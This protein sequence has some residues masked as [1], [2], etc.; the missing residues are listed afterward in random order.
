MDL[1]AVHRHIASLRHI[2]KLQM[3]EKGFSFDGKY[4]LYVDESV[5]VYVL[6]TAPITQSEKKMRE[7]EVV[8]RVYNQEVTT[9]EPV[10]FGTIVELDLCYMVLR[11][12]EGEDAADLLPA[13]TSDQQYQIGVEAGRQLLL[14]HQLDAPTSLGSWD[15]RRTAKHYRQLTAYQGCGVKIDHEARVIRFVEANLKYLAD[16]PN[17]FQHDDFHPSNLL[18]HNS[19]YSGVIDFN[20]YDWGDPYHD[21]MKVAYFS[22]QVS[23]PFSVGQIHG[24]FNEEIP[25]RFWQLYALYTALTLFPNITWTL[26]VVPDRLESMQERNRIVMEDHS[27]FDK[28]MPSWYTS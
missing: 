5:P 15:T 25:E 7:F 27:G 16:R 1:A 21:F 23:I 22:R 18:I 12:V 13:L 28:L 3:I 24:Y 17:Q 8:Q 9:S 4:F 26:Q 20:R 6:R 14:M 10:E 19:K 11:Y 2:K